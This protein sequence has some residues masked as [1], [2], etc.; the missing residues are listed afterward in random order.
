MTRTTVHSPSPSRLTSRTNL[1][2]ETRKG[3]AKDRRR[4]AQ[5][6][7]AFA[8]RRATSNVDLCVVAAE[9]GVAFS[10]ATAWADPASKGTLTTADLAVMPRDV[11]VPILRELA[12]VHGFDLHEKAGLARP[13]A[14]HFA[15]V[16]KDV[17]SATTEYAE[18]ISVG[19]ITAREARELSPKCIRAREAL[20]DIQVACA[21]RMGLV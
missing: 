5:E 15:S 6:A 17:T 13:L 3:V 18:A 9:C 19:V 14:E 2:P 4:D 1:R 21:E 8:F 12:A 7:A 20:T 16:L 11:A 10:K